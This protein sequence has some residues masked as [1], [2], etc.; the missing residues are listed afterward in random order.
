MAEI[1]RSKYANVDRDDV[2]MLLRRGEWTP[3]DA[4]AWSNVHSKE[5]PFVSV[6]AHDRFDPMCE[7]EWTL[8]MAAAW[9]IWRT[10]D[11]V[12]EHWDAYLFECTELRISEQTFGDGRTEVGWES[13]RR[14]AVSVHDI[15]REA[16][17][18]DPED[19][20]L[21]AK[22]KIDGLW[23]ELKSGGLEAT[24][25]PHFISVQGSNS[26][27][28]R[29]V[30]QSAPRRILIP[31]HE[32]I[33]LTQVDYFVG[34]K[35]S[36]A[37]AMDY[38][39]RYDEVRVWRDDVLRIWSGTQEATKS[40]MPNSDKQ[41]H[42]R[43]AEHPI[44]PVQAKILETADESWPDGR[45]PARKGDQYKSIQKAFETRGETSPSVKTITRAFLAAKRGQ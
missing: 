33:D 24:G 45:R 23:I 25:L 12:R 31:R 11:A 21:N 38:E 7:P 15:F 9:V 3:A 20:K 16:A 42:D 8:A 39:A 40:T 19:S 17:S 41:K 18:S 4:E 44:S 6:P 34:P 22:A 14:H 13:R 2:V 30:V 29:D 28:R 36:I 10:A 43:T 1:D 26:S 37:T 35:D 32:W 5:R 27:V